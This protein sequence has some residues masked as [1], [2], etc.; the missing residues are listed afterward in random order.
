[1]P[2]LFESFQSVLEN[3]NG[4][5]LF[6]PR[7]VRT[8]NVNISQ[9]AKE[10]AAYSSLSAGDVKNTIENL[11][12]VMSQHLQSSENVTLDGLGT[13]RMVMVSKGK[14]VETAEEVSAAQASLTV[15]FQPSFTRNVDHSL[16]TRSM[17]TGVKCVR[18]ER[19]EAAVSGGDD[20]GKKEEGGGGGEAPDPIL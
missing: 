17:V 5:K 20:D 14:G 16:A 1:M 10:I 2:V 19:G 12:T 13:F 18:F 7:V 11:I 8:G 15:R 6:Y 4:K 3:K 9:I